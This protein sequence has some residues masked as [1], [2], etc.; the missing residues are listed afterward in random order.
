MRRTLLSAAAFLLVTRLASGLELVEVVRQMERSVVRID[1]D[2]GLGSGVIVHDQGLILTNYHVIEGATRAQI[3]LK[4]GKSL[5]A[6]GFLVVDPLHDLALVKTDAFEAGAAV[7]LAT[8]MPS[9]GEKVAAF[10]NPKGFSFTTSEG[11][12]SA[13]RSGKELIETI[14]GDAYRYLGYS[15]DATWIQT[16][17]PISS[18]NS[19]GPLVNMN[20]QLV[21]LNTWT[22]TQGQ[23]LN[24][25]IGQTDIIRLL[26]RNATKP[27]QSFAALPKLRSRAVARGTDPDKF[28]LT[29]ST[30]RVFSYNVFHVEASVIART[31]NPSR[32]DDV[33]ILYP[34]G[35]LYALAGQEKGKLNGVTVAQYEGGQPMTLVT[36]VDGQRHGNLKTWSEDG[37]PIVYTQFAKGKHNGFSAFH[38][39]GKLAMVLQYKMDKLE[40]MQVMSGEV[41][42]EGYSSREAA[43]KNSIAKELFAKLDEKEKLIVTNEAMFRRKVREF[44]TDR[45]HEK[46]R[47][48]APERHA[49][50]RAR[51][52]QR[53]AAQTSLIMEMQ[54]RANGR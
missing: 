33:E 42:L 17:A 37:T 43:Q 28:K 30:G 24:F 51:S 9:I 44:E 50:T 39:N 8:A 21:G 40:W 22:H 29:L 32:D 11:I 36:Y 34:N 25:A 4:S 20:A 19:G 23:N 47:E 3:I 27:V 5:N 54:R 15:P 45:R 26:A 46:A 16:T 48:L 18:G 31:S 14:G 13:I 12:V 35:S 2:S 49:R 10:G 7:K 38:V 53:A 41:P 1:T 6:H 52:A